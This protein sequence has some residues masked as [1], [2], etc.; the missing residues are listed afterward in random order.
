FDLDNVGAWMRNLDT[1]IDL[2]A[3]ADGAGVDGFA[4]PFHRDLCGARGG[5]LVLDPVADALRLADD[6][7][8]WR[9]YQ[10]DPAVAPVGAAG[11][12]RV[13]WRGE[14]ERRRVG[15]PVVDASV[16]DNE[17]ARDAVVRH[18]RQRRGQR[19]EQARAVSLAIGLASFYEAHLDAWTLSEP[20]G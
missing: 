4:V 9:R 16:G 8:A 1:D 5:A 6:A 20:L 17:R 14:A 3:D 13:P 10:H 2:L 19:V 18:V 15:R 11:D 12:H 7:E